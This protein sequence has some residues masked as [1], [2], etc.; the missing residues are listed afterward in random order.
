MR[1]K[2]E[3]VFINMT[4]I[5]GYL[6]KKNKVSWIGG[7][8]LGSNGYVQSTES[9]SKVF[10]NKTFKNVLIGGTTT[11]RHLDLLKY[12]DS[13]FSES[14]WYKKIEIDHEFMVTKFIPNVIK[15]FK[16]GIINEEETKRGGNFIV[17]TPSRLFEIQQDYSVLEPAMGICAVGCGEEVAMGSLITTQEMD[18]EP[19]DKILKALE[20][21]EKYC[22]GVKRPF[23]ILCTDGRDDIIIR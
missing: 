20:A 12:S 21:A 1:I 11:F 7:D 2:K 19:K 16:D 17:A 18:M 9:P 14:D 5:I 4:C 6:D 22:C 13:L 15:L 3:E 8:S 10:R 23:R